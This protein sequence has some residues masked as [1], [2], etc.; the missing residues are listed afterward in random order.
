MTPSQQAK[1]TDLSTDRKTDMS[2]QSQLNNAAFSQI[3]QTHAA[4][5]TATANI[6]SSME[7]YVFQRLMNCRPC[8]DDMTDDQKKNFDNDI[9]ETFKH[10]EWI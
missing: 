10:R 8:L 1:N 7:Q 2:L 3:A 4:M 5:K 6:R 9:I